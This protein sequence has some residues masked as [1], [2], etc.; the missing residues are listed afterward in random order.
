MDASAATAAV[1]IAV[2]PHSWWEQLGG[3]WA[4]RRKGAMLRT[5]A[6]A[7]ADE[8][9]ALEAS[10]RRALAAARAARATGFGRSR[11]RYE[12]SALGNLERGIDR[13]PCQ[14]YQPL[15][16]M[17]TGGGMGMV[18]ATVSQVPMRAAATA[19]AAAGERMVRAAPRVTAGTPCVTSFAAA[20]DVVAVRRHN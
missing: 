20:A 19:A 12:S 13:A 14:C 16:G 15:S 10:P 1:D 6:A 17:E 11:S 7:E 18:Q 8:G 9:G 3:E 2:P 5:V 4:R